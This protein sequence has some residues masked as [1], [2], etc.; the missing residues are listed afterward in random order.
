LSLSRHSSPSSDAEERA[1]LL[2]DEID[3]FIILL[4]L[5]AMGLLCLSFQ[6]K[7]AIFRCFSVVSY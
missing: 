4:P 1:N 5:F 3:G 7:G 6:A 2:Y